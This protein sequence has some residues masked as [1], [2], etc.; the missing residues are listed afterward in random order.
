MH[1]VV[2]NTGILPCSGRSY[3]ALV[4]YVTNNSAIAEDELNLLAPAPLNV[5]I[6]FLKS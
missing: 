2:A 3:G 1:L 5:C 6:I 4:Q